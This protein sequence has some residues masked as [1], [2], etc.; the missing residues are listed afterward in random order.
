MEK[1][2]VKMRNSSGLDWKDSVSAVLTLHVPL[3]GNKLPYLLASGWRC[4]LSSWRRH[5]WRAFFS[6]GWLCWCNSY[7][8]LTRWNQRRRKSV[9]Q[10][11]V[12]SS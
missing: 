1:E 2:A 8:T 10:I 12:V 4:R 9:W 3:Q 11:N 6:A 7:L 5:T